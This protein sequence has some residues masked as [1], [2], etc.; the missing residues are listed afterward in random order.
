[1]PELSMDGFEQALNRQQID[2]VTH[3]RVVRLYDLGRAELDPNQITEARQQTSSQLER[4]LK[5]HGLKAGRLRIDH[6]I[7]TRQNARDNPGVRL[8]VLYLFV[9]IQIAGWRLWIW[10]HL[11]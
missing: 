10:R 8:T 11:W 2:L 3:L 9:T 1:M 6:S 5:Q 4:V 7:A